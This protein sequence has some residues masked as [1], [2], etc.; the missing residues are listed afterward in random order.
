MS[1][2]FSP[3]Y[4]E[5]CKARHIEKPG[6]G[7]GPALSLPDIFD[8]L[9]KYRCDE[10]TDYGCGKAM[11]SRIVNQTIYRWQNYDPFVAQYAAAPVPKNYLICCDVLEHIEPEK[12]D[13]VLDH[14]AHL[15][16]QVGLLVVCTEPA[17]ETFPDGTNL[18][19]IVEDYAWWHAKLAEKF[20]V[21]ATRKGSTY[22]NYEV[23][24]KR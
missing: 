19:L 8:F 1:M 9:R 15:I 18:H 17:R 12:L 5:L 7:T 23:I 22:C 24:P 16:K 4:A 21:V 11:V 2:L 10:I 14:I 13:A 3:E 6:W 20:T